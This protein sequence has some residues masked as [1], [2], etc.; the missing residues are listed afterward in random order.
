MD[1][2]TIL[3]VVACFVLVIIGIVTKGPLSA[4]M[5]L[6]SILIVLGGAFSALLASYPLSKLKNIIK[7]TSKAFGGKQYNFEDTIEQFSQL[8]YIA[9]KEGLLAMEKFVSDIDSDF[10]KRGILLIVDGTDPKMIRSILEMEV[11]NMLERHNDGQGIYR[12]LGKYTPAFGMVGTLI[13]LIIMLQNLSDVSAVG[14]AMSIAL[15]TTFYGSLFANAVFLPIADKLKVK[16]ES[17]A[18]YKAMVIEGIM[19]VQSGESPLMIK[20]KLKTF[21]PEKYRSNLEEDSDEEKK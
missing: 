20:E 11:D 5:D 19:A 8:S 9:K 2:S 13:G 10:M 14:P 6:G 3:G 12:T 4:F 17:E 1:L 18:T 16:S 7:V 15:V 21:L